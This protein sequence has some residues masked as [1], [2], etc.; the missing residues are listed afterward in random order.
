MSTISAELEQE[1]ANELGFGGGPSPA[2]ELE[3][4]AVQESE[5]F[6]NH[7]AAMADRSGRAQSLRRIA[8]A[9]ARSAYGGALAKRP[10]TIIEG[11]SEL[12]AAAELEQELMAA[13]SAPARE[14]L[15]PEMEHLGHAASE[16]ETEQEAAEH[17]LPLIPLAAKFL[18][19]M[20]AK[21]APALMKAGGALA[22]KVLPKV[23]AKVAPNLTRG[24]GNLARTLHR[25]PLTRNLLRTVPRIA[26]RT[27]GNLAQRAARGQRITPKLAGATLARQA[28]RVLGQPRQAVAAFRRSRL[29]DRRHHLHARRVLGPPRPG[30]ATVGGG[31]GYAGGGSGGYTGGMPA[32]VPGG[33]SAPVP[34][35]P[36]GGPVA[37]AAGSGCCPCPPPVA[38]CPSCGR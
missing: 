12:E 15:L 19:P 32:G 26:Q 7:L 25:S 6:F 3:G 21:A 30:S 14:A 20:A 4:P 23:I 2:A 10:T 18:L 11:E 1:F 8:F 36:Y 13:C 17:F 22:K 27:V 34:G 38:T 5:A 28:A 37:V 31:G 35:M 24:V 16:A 29:L 9:A 33:M